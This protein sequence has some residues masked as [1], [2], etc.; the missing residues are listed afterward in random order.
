MSESSNATEKQ[1]AD[2]PTLH[3]QLEEMAARTQGNSNAEG[4]QPQ[5]VQSP[6]RGK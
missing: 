6:I 2:L 5:A 1:S 3:R 4:N